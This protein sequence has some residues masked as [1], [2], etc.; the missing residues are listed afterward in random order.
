L[1][2]TLNDLATSPSDIP[3]ESILRSFEET[4][5][6]GPVPILRPNECRPILRRLRD[7]SPAAGWSTGRAASSRA[8]YDLATHPEVL[9]WVT[10]PLGEDVLLW[11]ASLVQRRPDEVHPWHTDVETA[12]QRGRTV[13]V[14]IG[15]ENTDRRSSLMLIPHSHR[16]GTSLQEV[17]FNSGKRRG[18]ATTDEVVRWARSRDPRSGVV[19]YDMGDGEALIFDGRLWHGSR[20]ARRRGSRTALLLQYATPDT[21]I[22][23]PDPEAPFEWPFKFLEEPRPPCILVHGTDRHGVNRVVGPPAGEAVDSLRAAPDVRRIRRHWIRE[24][25]RTLEE[26]ARTGWKL[27][28][29]FHGSTPSMGELSSHVSVLS[30]GTEPH[31]PHEHREEELII[32][33]SG[34]AGVVKVDHSA[35]QTTTVE[36]IGPGSFVYHRD[37]QR[38]T[39]RAIGPEPATY[40]IFKWHAHV[41]DGDE[42]VLESSVFHFE[43]NGVK[44]GAGTSDEVSYQTIVDAP[45]RYLRKLQSHMTVV[46]PGAGY[47][48]HRDP[49]DVVILVLEG[50]VETLG[51]QVGPRGVIFCPAGE[52]HGLK[53]V[54]STPAK[55]LVFEFHGRDPR[56]TMGLREVAAKLSSAIPRKVARLA[57]RVLSYPRSRRANH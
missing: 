43:G 11:G 23:M 50:R 16:F 20:N 10:A 38:H 9:R 54:A 49:Y 5:Y 57:Y 4:G 52:P 8:F 15:L 28:P 36:N 56:F 47:P 26:D 41:A 7:S 32:M 37:R 17:G 30:A 2:A 46:Q 51:R 29:L 53:N 45:T 44:R 18:E 21:R 48:P 24:I 34:E 14:W 31:A 1:N 25:D 35:A 40:L 13:T 22:R 27:Y 6:L 42:P 55:Y 33:L 3:D 12:S 19:Q 39:I